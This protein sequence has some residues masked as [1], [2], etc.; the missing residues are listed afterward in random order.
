MGGSRKI[1][2]VCVVLFA[3]VSLTLWRTDTGL[4][5]GVNVALAQAKTCPDVVKAALATTDKKCAT[6]GRNK[7]CYGNIALSAEAQPGAPKFTFARPGDTANL[8]ALR[9]IHLSAL[10]PTNN[11]WGIVVLRV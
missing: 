1:F 8:N 6:T 2:V 5:P 11:T 3:I 10:D 7:A 4:T 9:T